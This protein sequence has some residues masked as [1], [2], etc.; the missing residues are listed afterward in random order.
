MPVVLFGERRSARTSNPDSI[1][2]ANTPYTGRSLTGRVLHSNGTAEV[3]RRRRVA[4][5]APALGSRRH[6]AVLIDS[7]LINPSRPCSRPSFKG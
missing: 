1:P 6:G 2:D 4:S 3:R 5:P 7:Q